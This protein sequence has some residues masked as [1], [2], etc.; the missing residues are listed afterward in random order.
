MVERRRTRA[1]EEAGA[2]IGEQRSGQPSDRQ[3]GRRREQGHDDVLGEQ[4]GGDQARCAADR[5]EQSDAADLVGH[6]AS[7]EDRDAG[8]G[9]QGEQPGAGQQR[10]P[11]VLDQ[12]GA[13]FADVLP[14]LQER[15]RPGRMRACPAVRSSG[16]LCASTNAGAAAGSASF[17]FRT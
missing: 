8:H 15:G 4:H 7:D 6:P 11:L 1:A 17:R 14:G 5:L 3:P 2:G 9:E 16:G 13:R 12:V 10:S